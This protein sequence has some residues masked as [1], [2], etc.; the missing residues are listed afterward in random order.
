M[1][2]EELNEILENHRLW[3]E[4]HAKGECADLSHTDLSHTDLSRADLRCSDL[5]YINLKYANLN[6]A[7]LIGANLSHADLRYA[8]LEK[9]S[10]IGANLSKANL[11]KA[12]LNRV[13]LE[14]IKIYKTTLPK[15]YKILNSVFIIL[16]NKKDKII[17]IGC[18]CYTIEKW[19]QIGLNIANMEGLTNKQI[20]ILKDDIEW[21]EMWFNKK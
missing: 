21:I 12:N 17:K 13:A 4:N 19:K 18:E 15:N 3:L 8:N 1:N 9:A 11:S 7:D 10:L 2:Q 6:E 14:E 5:S 16:A 20:E